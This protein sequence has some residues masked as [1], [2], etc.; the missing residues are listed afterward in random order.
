MEGWGIHLKLFW[1]HQ[2]LLWA[3]LF[4]SIQLSPAPLCWALLSWCQHSASAAKRS[5]ATSGEAEKNYTDHPRGP[6]VWRSSAGPGDH[7]C[8]SLDSACFILHVPPAACPQCECGLPPFRTS[9]AFSGSPGSPA[10][11]LS[12]FQLQVSLSKDVIGEILLL[13]HTQTDFKSSSS[14]DTFKSQQS[15]SSRR[16]LPVLILRLLGNQRWKVAHSPT[17]KRI[18]VPFRFFAQLGVCSCVWQLCLIPGCHY[19][20]V[21]Q[22]FHFSRQHVEDNVVDVVNTLSPTPAHK[23]LKGRQREGIWHIPCLMSTK[24]AHLVGKSSASL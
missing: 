12:V 13:S 14:S 24:L 6:E 1:S 22:L 18:F 11:F 23:P 19:D 20:F 3:L 5:V 4:V 17:V 8:F 15:K 10:G 21:L 16:Y 9:V 2:P 7:D